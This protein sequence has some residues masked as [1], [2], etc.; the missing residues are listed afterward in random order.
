[1]ALRSVSSGNIAQPPSRLNSRFCI[2]L[3]AALV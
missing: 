2:S 1:M 3:A